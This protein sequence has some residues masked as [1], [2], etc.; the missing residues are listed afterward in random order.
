MIKEEDTVIEETNY[1]VDSRKRDN[2][3]TNVQILNGHKQFETPI[4]DL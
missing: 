2:E 1:K 4:C 3:K